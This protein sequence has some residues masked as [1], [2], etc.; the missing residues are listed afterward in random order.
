MLPLSGFREPSGWGHRPRGERP[1]P[2][3]RRDR[4]QS[5]LRW[6]AHPPLPIG[7]DHWH[8]YDRLLD[9]DDDLA[10]VIEPPSRDHARASVTARAVEVESGDLAA[11]GWADAVGL[12]PGLLILD[13]LVA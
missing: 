8:T 6:P 1:I 10:G 12:G 4:E 11:A 7:S 3:F 13:G 5:T 2:P 9:E